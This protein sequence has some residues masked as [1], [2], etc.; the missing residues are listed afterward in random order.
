MKKAVL[1]CLFG[2][3]CGVMQAQDKT[4]QRSDIEIINLGMSLGAKGFNFNTAGPGLSIAMEYRY[5]IRPVALDFGI[6]VGQSAIPKRDAAEH[7]L[8]DVDYV[9]RA[10]LVA[11][12][13]VNIGHDIR[14]FIGIGYGAYSFAWDFRKFT[15]MPRAGFRIL[16]HI[17]IT[18]DY[19]FADEKCRHARLGF[20][21]FF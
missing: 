4:F 1:F 16:D 7:G 12:Y 9:R 10:M 14:P 3:F 5:H 2:L 17:S 8:F 21:Y 19:L 11:D 6:L 15:L 13:S 20:G 18:A